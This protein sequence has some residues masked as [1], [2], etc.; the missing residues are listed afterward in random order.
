MPPKHLTGDTTSAS[1]AGEVATPEA[2]PRKLQ[3]PLLPLEKVPDITILICSHRGRDLRCGIYG[4]VLR[5]EFKNQ[6]SRANIPIWGTAEYDP[7]STR[8][9]RVGLISHIGGHAFAGNAI[10][11]IPPTAITSDQKP[12][13]L[14][15]W[16]VWYGRVEPS[17]VEG[18]VKET[19]LGGRI[20][21]V[22]LRGGI[23][24]ERN[25]F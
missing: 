4:P 13:P 11:Y 8:A 1:A 7:K 17:H 16:G 24:G 23:N 25:I 18:I 14:A 22:L 15:G 9:A 3:N 2:S 19:I 6:L 20:I 12:H 10:I 5:D 21:D